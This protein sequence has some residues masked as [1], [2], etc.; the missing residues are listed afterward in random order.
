MTQHDV[1]VSP[2][3]YERLRANEK[4]AVLL[5]RGD[6]D[7]QAGDSIRFWRNDTDPEWKYSTER[8][9]GHVCGRHDGLDTRYVLLS[10]DDPRVPLLRERMETAIANAQKLARSKSALQSAIRRLRG[11]K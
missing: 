6:R 11:V 9:I 7:Y 5:F 4:N 2:F 3:E 1:K 10:L 8:T